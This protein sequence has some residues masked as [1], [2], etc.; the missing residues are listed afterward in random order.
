[1][2][3]RP[4]KAVE[5]WLEPILESVRLEYPN[6]TLQLKRGTL[7]MVVAHGSQRRLSY[8]LTESTID[9]IAEGSEQIK[10]EIRQNVF[11]LARD[12]E[13]VISE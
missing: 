1:M 4:I 11:D 3:Q 6:V 12:S 8:A 13:A 10:L 5:V 2:D 7:L 9:R